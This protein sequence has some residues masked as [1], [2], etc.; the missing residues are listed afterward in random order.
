MSRSRSVLKILSV[1]IFIASCAKPD[2]ITNTTD[3]ESSALMAPDKGGV[4]TTAAAATFCAQTFN[5]YAP[6]YASGIESRL[7]RLA[8]EVKAEPCDVIQFQEFWRDGDYAKFKQ[9]MKGSSYVLIRAD[10]L[11]NDNVIIGL[12]SA[13]QGKISQA[14]SS[15]FRVNNEGGILDGIRNLAGVQKGFTLLKVEIANTPSLLL[16]NLHTHPD[17]ESIRLA[18]VTQLVQDIVSHPEILDSPIVLTGDLNATPDSPELALV[19]DLLL[20]RDSFVEANSSYGGVC[21]YCKDNPLS[22]DNKDRVIDFVLIGN[23]LSHKLTSKTSVINLKGSKPAP[24][25]DHF[26]VRSQLAW[27]LQAERELNIMDPLILSRVQKARQSLSRA[28]K[29][30]NSN[31]AA[32]FR[33]AAKI[34]KQ[35]DSEFASGRLNPGF[36]KIFRTP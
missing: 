27:T 22:W 3:R 18:Q 1:L 28:I 4:D 33:E 20:L 32:G 17:K 14:Q 8:Q 31:S 9:S 30:L 36:E 7:S 6:A 23:S 25:S 26:G 10:D 35:W 11:R 19:K 5:V 29:V 16:L 34:L 2:S 21:T 15:V 12:S 24:L 13:I